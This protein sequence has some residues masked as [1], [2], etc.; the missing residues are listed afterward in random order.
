VEGGHYDWQPCEV[1]EKWQSFCRTK[2][3]GEAQ[4]A[5]SARGTER[6]DREMR[7]VELELFHI[8]KRGESNSASLWCCN[9]EFPSRSWLETPAKG[10]PPV[11]PLT[12][13][14]W[15]RMTY[16]GGLETM[17][18]ILI[19][20][21]LERP[22]ER[23]DSQRRYAQLTRWPMAGDTADQVRRP[24]N[25]AR[26]MEVLIV[27]NPATRL[28]TRWRLRDWRYASSFPSLGWYRV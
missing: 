28:H 16:P 12:R 4:K 7:V 2:Y 5:D 9:C 27:S 19:L 26:S 11:P 22:H 15:P 14:P 17:V 6:H 3:A 20:V 1:R 23:K 10:H 13:D 8:L 18:T 25:S 24:M 21:V